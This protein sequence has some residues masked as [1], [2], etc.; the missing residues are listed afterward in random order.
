MIVLNAFVEVVPGKENEFL[1]ATKPLI[2]ETRKE[3]GNH[4]YQLYQ[5]HNEFVFIEYWESQKVLDIHSK[6]EHFKAFV[7]AAGSL[8]AKP[9]KIESYTK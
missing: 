6:S 9:L 5:H 7:E 1:A 3:L 2:E 8:F 4:L